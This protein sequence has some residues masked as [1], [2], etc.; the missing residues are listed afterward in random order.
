MTYVFEMPS[1]AKD[2]AKEGA[3]EPAKKRGRKASKSAVPKESVQKELPSALKE[4][5]P[6]VI[7]APKEAPKALAAPKA[8]ITKDAG[9]RKDASAQEVFVLLNG[10]RLKNVK[11]LADVMGKLEDHVFNHHVN[12]ARNDFAQWLKDVFKEVDLAKEVSGCRD[13][14]RLQLVLYKHISHKLW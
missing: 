12:D 2:P 10:Q 7:V 4:P 3:K 5:V 9:V 14:N 11:E 8:E 13:K 6:K 1:A